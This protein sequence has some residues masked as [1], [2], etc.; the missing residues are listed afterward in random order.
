LLNGLCKFTSRHPGKKKRIGVRA[1]YGHDA[2]T[3][4]EGQGI[5][6]G[7]AHGLK[8]IIKLNIKIIKK[9]M[10][11]HGSFNFEINFS[12]ILSEATIIERN[13]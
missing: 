11:A 1:V 12:I 7:S 10:H 2:G 6:L 9:A 3:V 4:P 8:I 5:I 13:A